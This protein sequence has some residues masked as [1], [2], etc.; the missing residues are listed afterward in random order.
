MAK[1]N[2][3][4]EKNTQTTMKSRNLKQRIENNENI[5]IINKKGKQHKYTRKIKRKK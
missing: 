2:E 1:N 3:Q 5:K 4:Q